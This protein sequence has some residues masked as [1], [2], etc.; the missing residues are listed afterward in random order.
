ML[1][2][3]HSPAHSTYLYVGIE[4]RYYGHNAKPRGWK[5][6]TWQWLLVCHKKGS[7]EAFSALPSFIDISFESVFISFFLYF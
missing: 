7:V 6:A 4:S 2:M 5:F 1:S 3:S